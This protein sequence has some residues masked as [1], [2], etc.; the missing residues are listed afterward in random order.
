[1]TQFKSETLK[2]LSERGFVNQC[3]DLEALD[4]ALA[5]GPVTAY[6]GYDPTAPS[7]HIGH[8]ITIMMLYWLQQT[9]HRP[10]TLM[11]GG[12]GMIGDPSFKDSSRP[13]MTEETIQTNMNGIKS[14]FG[15]LLQYGSGKNDAI[16]VNNADW[17]KNL[18][19]IDFLR[20]YG[21]LFSVNRMLSFDSIKTR[22]DREQHLSFLE[23]NYSILQ[24][25]DFIELNNLHG[26]TL[27]VSGAD[28]W[29][30]A[31]SG[32]EL[33]RKKSG[34]NLH[35]L[36]APLLTDASG[37]KMGKSEGNALWLNRDLQS[38]YD[39]Y[40]YWRN[41]DDSMVE[42]MLKLFT[43]LPLDEIARLSALKDAE[44]NE[45]KKILAFEATKMLRGQDAAERSAQTAAETFA[46]GGK[47][48]DLP[49][50]QLAAHESRS[51][52]DLLVKA[53][54][55]ASKG[56]AKRLIAGKGIKINDAPVE[57]EAYQISNDDF[58][59]D[60]DLKLSAGKKRHVLFSQA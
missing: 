42:K 39:Y 37:K 38:D 13:M 56:E 8:L 26:C 47:G 32:A 17:L 20:D 35:V 49:R 9:G 52:L 19:Y 16:M 43:A 46:G 41:V 59:S 58:D 36:T 3:T 31:I 51:I 10:I 1:M 27:Q 48:A 25:Y 40:Q 34:L 33:G 7:L 28:Q 44:I 30:N 4:A 21:T 50:F 24:A 2:I 60:G 22:L 6:C 23:F 53:E 55:A 54:L 15:S 45:A 18:G 12:T 5:S 29:A 57:D 14:V 11:G